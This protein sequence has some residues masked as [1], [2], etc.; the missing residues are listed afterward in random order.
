MTGMTAA[1]TAAAT[2]ASSP[3]T[4]TT[5]D[6]I[7]RKRKKKRKRL[8]A[9]RARARERDDPASSYA[10]DSVWAT[11]EER[12]CAVPAQAFVPVLTR[13]GATVDQPFSTRERK[14]GFRGDTAGHED[15][16]TRARCGY[17]TPLHA[18]EDKLEL[19]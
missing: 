11:T 6:V 18:R 7:R 17:S 8:P 19:P 16:D 4:R 12:I 3:T 2:T 1:A 9:A 13:H 14:R 5:R 15:K 10:R